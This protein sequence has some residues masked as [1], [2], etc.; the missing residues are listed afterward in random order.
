M[1]NCLIHSSV[2]LSVQESRF[3]IP[4][5]AWLHLRTKTEKVVILNFKPDTSDGHER[6]RDGIF[7]M[8]FQRKLVWNNSNNERK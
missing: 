5:H 8:G 7:W 4:D 1:M 3:M 6:D 2:D